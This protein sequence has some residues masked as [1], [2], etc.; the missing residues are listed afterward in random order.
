MQY[1]VTAVAP[2]KPCAQLRRLFKTNARNILL[3]MMGG[4]GFLALSLKVT[5]IK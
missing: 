4:G 2:C 5:D 3:K 1:S